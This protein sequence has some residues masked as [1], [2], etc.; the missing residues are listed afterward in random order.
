MN[1]QQQL[2]K[3]DKLIKSYIKRLVRESL[4]TMAA[5]YQCEEDNS[6][7]NSQEKDDNRRNIETEKAKRR[8]VQVEKFLKQDSINPAEYF[9]RLFGAET[10][11]DK[12]NARGL[13]YKKRDHELND[14]GYPYSF[15]SEEINKLYSMISSN[16]L[17]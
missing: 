9:Y 14:D 17:S 7:D 13:G 16:S 12:A 5:N 6:G 2:L 8:R 11:E 15:T 4:E 10:D 1:K 3:E